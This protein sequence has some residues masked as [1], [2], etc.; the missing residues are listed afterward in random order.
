M[1]LG[2]DNRLDG[3]LTSD[4]SDTYFLTDMTAGYCLSI[5]YYLVFEKLLHIS[6]LTKYSSRTI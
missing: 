6:F 2:D 1:T 3:A 4:I 5:E